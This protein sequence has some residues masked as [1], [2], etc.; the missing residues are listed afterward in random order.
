MDAQKPLIL[1]SSS[2]ARNKLLQQLRIPFTVVSPNID[3]SRLENES[4]TAMLERLA[5]TKAAVTAQQY[6]N[7]F[8]IGCDEVGLFQDQILTKPLTHSAAVRQL[9]MIS[10]QRIQF[11]TSLCLLNSEDNSHQ[12]SIESYTVTLRQLSHETIENYLKTEKPYQ[13][14]GSLQVE[15]LG[16]ALC[17][18]LEGED[19]N[20]LIGLPLIKLVTMLNRVGFQVI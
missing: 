6:P 20:A 3:E 16:I 14:A 18:K 4:A 8:I 7:A 17:E 9:D 19:I 1:S 5:F 15:G 11:F 12:L 2:P 10:G 13:C